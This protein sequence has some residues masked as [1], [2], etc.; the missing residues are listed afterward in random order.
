MNMINR[1]VLFILLI[2][3][4]VVSSCG[5]TKPAR[6]Y[7]LTPVSQQDAEQSGLSGKPEITIGIG[8]MNV[9]EYLERPQIMTHITEN[10]VQFSEYDNLTADQKLWC[11]LCDDA[12]TLGTANDPAILITA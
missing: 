4:V 12:E 11:A 5:S 7:L 10:E 8:T 3:M 6:F 9:P 1:V 2:T